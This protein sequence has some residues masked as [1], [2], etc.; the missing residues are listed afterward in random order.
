MV[1]WDSLIEGSYWVDYKAQELYILTCKWNFMYSLTLIIVYFVGLLKTNFHLVLNFWLVLVILFS[2]WMRTSLKA[3][4]S[5][6]ESLW[7]FCNF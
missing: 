1:P 5:L 6:N 2:N 7:E 4:D 3:F